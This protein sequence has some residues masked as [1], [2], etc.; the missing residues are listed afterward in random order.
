M[1]KPGIHIRLLIAAFFLICAA[2]FTLDVVGVH[3]TRQFMHK[4]F[5]DRISFLAKYLALNSEVG[6]LI[7][8]RAGLKSLALN[9]LG[10]EDVARVTIL[11]D[12]NNQLVDLSR[13][14][15]GPLSVVEAPVLFK[16]NRDENV[17]FTDRSTPF[18]KV[19]IPGEEHIGKVRIDFSTYGIDNLMAEITRQF[20][21]FSCGLAILAGIIF[22]FLSRSIVVEVTR[23][24]DTARQVG[25]GN[26]SL[27]ARPG[28]LPETRDLGL[29]FNAMLDSLARSR[30][31]L[32]RANAEMMRQ[33]ALAEM[34][35]FSS[36]IAHEVKN[37]LSIIK[38]SLDVLKKDPSEPT[39]ATMI[40]YMEDEIKRLNR[41]IEDFLAFARPV[42][43]SFRPVDLNAML[44]EIVAR[45]EMQK[46]GSSIEVQA[47]IP[48]VPCYANADPDLLTRALGNIL[49]NACE[50]NGEKGVVRMTTSCEE[51]TWAVEIEDEGEGI[52]PQHF[53]QIFEPFFTTRS[54]GSGLGLAF[55]SQV[56]E[57]HGGTITAENRME[58]GAR[59]RV[60]IPIGR[61]SG[62]GDQ[63]SGAGGEGSGN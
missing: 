52:A 56:I 24:A 39:S 10:E 44:K 40:A 55:A 42:S 59:F 46:S 1:K 9:L 18:G 14:V 29:A 31:A 63:G 53:D 36:M 25:Q 41:L 23:L 61:G 8:D 28:S 16:K 21:W 6:V 50:A 13:P 7:G 33:N 49:K 58:G 5:R 34:G 35:K 57:S 38:S 47:Q 43:P 27:R 48:S 45:F 26:L 20:I 19:R 60:E 51:S 4:R 3:I 11:D 17:L 62:I 22:Y 37:P 15:P 2:T 32:A 30:E 12:H 54:K